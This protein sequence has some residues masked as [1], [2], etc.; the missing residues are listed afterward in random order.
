MAAETISPHPDVE[1]LSNAELRE[2]LKD[3]DENLELFH[4]LSEN[5]R[6]P[7]LEPWLIQERRLILAELNRRNPGSDSF[8]HLRENNPAESFSGLLTWEQFLSTT[9][10]TREWTV[11]EMIPESELGV[12]Q[13]RGWRVSLRRLGYLYRVMVERITFVQ[14]APKAKRSCRQ[15]VLMNAENR[16]KGP[17]GEICLRYVKRE[18]S[19]LS[20]VANLARAISFLDRIEFGGGERIRT[21]AS[22]F[23]RPLP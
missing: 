14:K 2:T 21:A 17:R 4:K 16:Y 19:F 11:H 20:A 8:P 5:E 6:D 22:R 23:C 10:A 18:T 15:E 7:I 3:A 1:C 13:G 12:I 9:P